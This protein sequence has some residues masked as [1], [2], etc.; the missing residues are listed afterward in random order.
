MKLNY[1]TLIKSWFSFLK[2]ASK[3]KNR[4][5]RDYKRFDNKKF[6]ESLITCFITGKNISYDA[7]ENLVLKTLDKMAPIKQ[8][9]N[10]GKQSR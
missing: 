5:Y 3:S 10:R 7:F 1:L 9:H 8:K 6:E 4:N 2:Q